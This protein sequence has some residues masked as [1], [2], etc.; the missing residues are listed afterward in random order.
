MIFESRDFY[1]NTIEN[2]DIEEI[3]EIYN[4]NEHF[5]LNH[6][7]VNNVT[8]KWML[9]EIT[10]ARKTGFKSCKIVDK[11]SGKKIGIV[12]FKLGEE[13]YLS[14]LMI[15]NDFRGKGI[16]K[17]FFINFEEYLK[18]LK[19]KSIRIDVVTDYD[20]SVFDFWGKNGFISFQDVKLNWAG[21]ILSAVTMRKY[22]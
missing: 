10:C 13:T 19:S 5:L 4:S 16:G 21:N 20:N 17:V 14:L 12:D 6:M 18:S 15:H 7:N 8:S 3:C 22:L 2:N 1:I 11:A 9:E